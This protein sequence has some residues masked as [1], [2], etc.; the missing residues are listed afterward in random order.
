MLKSGKT[1]LNDFTFPPSPAKGRY[2]NDKNKPLCADSVVGRDVDGIG[3]GVVSDC[4][5]EIGDAA[6]TVSLDQNV[7]RL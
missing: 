1:S 7:L 5:A 3:G 2:R 4:E 6:I